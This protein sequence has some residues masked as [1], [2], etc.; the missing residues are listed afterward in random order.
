[1]FSNPCLSFFN[2]CSSDKLPHVQLSNKIIQTAC[3]LNKNI[4]HANNK[5]KCIQ[6]YLHKCTSFHMGNASSLQSHSLDKASDKCVM[7]KTNMNYHKSYLLHNKYMKK[8]SI[9]NNTFNK[10][11]N[12]P[13]VGFNASNNDV[14]NSDY[15]NSHN[16]KQPISNLHRYVKLSNDRY[17]VNRYSTRNVYNGNDIMFRM[18]NDQRKSDH[19]K[20]RFSL[21]EKQKEAY[22]ISGGN[23]KSVLIPKRKK[24]IRKV[25]FN[26]GNK[27]MM[28]I[29]KR[30]G[31]VVVKRVWNEKKGNNGVLGCNMGHKKIRNSV[32]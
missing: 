8:S 11:C 23:N 22:D 21:N 15:F 30:L 13:F 3:S 24:T 29:R 32:I 20:E 19:R 16:A 5:P 18:E 26:A 9:D 12:T 31:V 14:S 25:V 4:Y 6:S 2:S 10:S 7:N 17:N 27:E 1:M 28:I